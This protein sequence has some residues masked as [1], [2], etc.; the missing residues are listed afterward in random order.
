MEE[1]T[2]TIEEH[3]AAL[4]RIMR[5]D[6]NQ[7]ESTIRFGHAKWLN[8]KLVVFLWVVAGFSA[9]FVI[10]AFLMSNNHEYL[11][12]AAVFFAIA[13]ICLVLIRALSFEIII[14]LAESTFEFKGQLRKNL[15]FTL[16]DYEGA[17]TRLTV[18]DFP[19]EFWVNFRTEKGTK[20]F[21]LADLNMGRACDIEPNHKA[22]CA[23]WDAIIRQMQL[24]NSN[25]ESNNNQE[26]APD[27]EKGFLKNE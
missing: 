15:V 1:I 8:K 13:L 24:N 6:F 19:E 12:V 7:E 17:E 2:R 11:T 9:N 16:A 27:T 22:V 20:S 26:V 14:N 5:T 18:K 4:N 21:K 25:P 3:K 23:L 10:A